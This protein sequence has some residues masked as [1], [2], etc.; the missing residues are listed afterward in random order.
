[1]AVSQAK[2]VR[3][4]LA[5]VATMLLS[6]FMLM[7]GL[8]VLPFMALP[9]AFLLVRK[10]LVSA[11]VVVASTGLVFG[12][13]VSWTTAAIIALVLVFLGAAV[14]VSVRKRWSFKYSL[15][16]VTAGALVMLVGLLLLSWPAGGLHAFWTQTVNSA[17]AFRVFD[18][19]V[20]GRFQHERGLE[21]GSLVD[22]CLALPVA[23]L[24]GCG[25]AWIGGLR[26][27]ARPSAGAKNEG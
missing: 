6:A 9:V 5:L 17:V 2:V 25:C 1:M 15:F 8:I 12:L 24:S 27:W 3:F 20:H 16:A 21:Q 26:G 11:A 14:S 22:G 18:Q 10:E 4:V 19:H 23:G 13:A 7:F